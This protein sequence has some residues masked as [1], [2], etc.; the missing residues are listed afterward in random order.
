LTTSIVANEN[1]RRGSRDALRDRFVV[2]ELKLL[3]VSSSVAG[4]GEQ[5]LRGLAHEAVGCR[6]CLSALRRRW[7]SPSSS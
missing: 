4:G 3:P 2:G 7:D 1:R 5:S 6:P